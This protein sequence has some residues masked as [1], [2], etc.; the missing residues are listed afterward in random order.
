MNRDPY[1]KAL[2]ALVEREGGYVHVAE[3]AHVSPDNLWQVLSGTKLPSGNPR[4]LGPRLRAK[5][6]SAFPDWLDAAAAEQR[7]ERTTKKSPEEDVL[8]IAQYAAGGAMGRGLVLE[9]RPPGFIKAWRVDHE[10]LRLN[11]RHHSGVHNLRIVTGF[12]PSMRPMFNPG[13]PL[14]L[15]VG[16]E[17]VDHDAVYF[18]RVGEHGF[19]K[20]LQRIPTSDGMAIRAKSKNPDYDPFDITPAMQA[21]DGYFEV[22]GKVLTVWRSEVL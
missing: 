7:A 6:T 8:T 2:E 12:G 5:L 1:I 20:T 15:D 19:I 10:W 13:D 4:G 18:F 9:D 16:F 21:Q 14:L 22:F 11:V 17:S 3:K